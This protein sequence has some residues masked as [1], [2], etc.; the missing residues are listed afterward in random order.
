MSKNNLNNLNEVEDGVNIE[1]MKQTAVMSQGKFQVQNIVKDVFGLETAVESVPLPSRGVI[2]SPESP[3]YGQETLQIR[4]MTA[5][6]EDILM[7]RAY[8]KNGTVIQELIKSCLINKSIDVDEMIAGDRNAL[9][10]AL[11]ITGYGAEY[12]VE[13]DCPK[14]NKSSVQNFNL[15]ELG[16]KRLAIDPI[17]E[18]SNLFEIQL[19]ISKKNIRIKFAN[20]YDEKELS[21]IQDRKKKMGIQQDTAITDRLQSAIVS[22]QGITDKTKIGMFIKEMPARDSLA[23]RKFL[24]NNEPGIDMSVNMQCKHCFEESEVKLPIGISFF[25]PNT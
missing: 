9:M 14:C 22:V 25:W 17:V 10:I 18:G 1:Q 11:R 6:D 13:C 24:D 4:A 20:G 15:S 12:E 21:T 5:R 8:I 16:I 3:L 23:L 2:Y 19:P 7:S